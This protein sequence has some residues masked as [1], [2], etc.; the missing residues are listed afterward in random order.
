MLDLPH[1]GQVYPSRASVKS[2]GHSALSK[3][4]P[5]RVV[6]RELMASPN[7]KFT[8]LLALQPQPEV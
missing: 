7:K 1:F 4:A 6:E 2:S 8:E 3:G 5:L